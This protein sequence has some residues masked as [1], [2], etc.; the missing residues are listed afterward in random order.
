MHHQCHSTPSSLIHLYTCGL[1]SI[2]SFRSALFLQNGAQTFSG[3]MLLSVS[4]SLEVTR[5]QT[6]PFEKDSCTLLQCVNIAVIQPFD[7]QLYRLYC[8]FFLQEVCY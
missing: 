5:S 8:P 4:I 6:L 3:S 7:S 2:D 1:I